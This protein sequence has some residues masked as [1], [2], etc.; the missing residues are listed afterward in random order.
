MSRNNY[1][2]HALGIWICGCSSIHNKE[3]WASKFAGFN[4]TDSLKS[5]VLKDDVP[6]TN[7]FMHQVQE[8]CY[9]G[10]IIAGAEF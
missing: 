8:P 5:A 2:K 4:R 6:K 7:G 3:L 9:L 1:P 10:F